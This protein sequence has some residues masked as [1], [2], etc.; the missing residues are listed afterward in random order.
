MK[1]KKSKAAWNKPNKGSD[2]R[3]MATKDQVFKIETSNNK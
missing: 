3:H 2:K 1:V